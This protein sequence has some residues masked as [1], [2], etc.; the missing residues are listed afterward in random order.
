MIG[1]DRKL[2]TFDEVLKV[3]DREVDGQEFPIECAVLGLCGLE[4]LGKVDNWTPLISNILLQ[5][6]SYSRMYPK[7][8]T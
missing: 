8:R 7:H 4:L 2:T 3:F 6:C 1:V 5:Y